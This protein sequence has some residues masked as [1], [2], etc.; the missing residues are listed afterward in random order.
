MLNINLLTRVYVKWSI[1]AN[2]LDSSLV[3][4]PYSATVY[5]II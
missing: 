5:Y 1:G 4:Y 2:L 3:D